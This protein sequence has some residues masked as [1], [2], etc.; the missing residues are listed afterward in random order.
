M[1]AISY[2]ELTSAMIYGNVTINSTP[3]LTD[4]SRQRL[5]DGPYEAIQAAVKIWKYFPQ[6]VSVLYYKLRGFEISRRCR[7]SWHSVGR[8]T[9]RR[10]RLQVYSGN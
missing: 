8:E 9:A 2:S 6:Q 7:H 1:C 3:P 10:S 4:H 5:G